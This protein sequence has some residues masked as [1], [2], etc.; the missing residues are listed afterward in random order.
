ECAL[1]S[2]ANIALVPTQDYLGLDESARMNVPSVAAGNWSWRLKDER[3]L[4]SVSAW[5]KQKVVENK[6]I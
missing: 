4:K 2:K 3:K 6:R 1:A 5:I